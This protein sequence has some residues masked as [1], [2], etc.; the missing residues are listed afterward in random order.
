VLL[1]AVLALMKSARQASGQ[2]RPLDGAGAYL[3]QFAGSLPDALAGILQPVAMAGWMTL[4]G[5]LIFGAVVGLMT[6]A[7]GAAH[8]GS[9]L[10]SAGD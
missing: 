10:D 8:H 7:V 9:G 2:T 4:A 6:A 3:L 5:L 1:S